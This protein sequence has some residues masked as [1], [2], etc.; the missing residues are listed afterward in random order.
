MCWRNVI[1]ADAFDTGPV[2]DAGAMSTRSG[3]GSENAP[4]LRW[5]GPST[6]SV[7]LPAVEVT[8]AIVDATY[9]F[10]TPGAKR[11]NCAGGPSVSASVAGTVP[12][13]FPDAAQVQ[14]STR[15]RSVT[16]GGIVSAGEST[17]AL[18]G[19]AGSTQPAFWRGPCR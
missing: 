7:A 16:A 18:A 15:S 3:S 17:Y 2:H 1:A 9:S 8:F 11:P 5:P 14:A 4:L 19:S 6:L 10:A 13:T 12:L